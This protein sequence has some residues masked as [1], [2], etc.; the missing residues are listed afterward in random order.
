VR[1]RAA[2]ASR[3]INHLLQYGGIEKV[4]NESLA[5]L[6]AILG[7]PAERLLIIA[8]VAVDMR[9]LVILPLLYHVMQ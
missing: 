4:V 9:N 2:T 5:I 7:W 8:I 3:V 1:T 6:L